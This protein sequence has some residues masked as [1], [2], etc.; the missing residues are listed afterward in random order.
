MPNIIDSK[1]VTLLLPYE[2]T[3]IHSANGYQ[4]RIADGAD[5]GDIGFAHQVAYD[6]YL[7]QHA[8]PETCEYCLCGPPLMVQSVLAML[9]ELGV[10]A[11]NI[12]YDDFGIER[13][14][15]ASRV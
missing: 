4:L 7:A 12:H 14:K 1:P 15:S 9:D 11:E 2:G 5:S 3:S 13:D 6:R 10:D 8:A